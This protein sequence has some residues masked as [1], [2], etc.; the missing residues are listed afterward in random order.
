MNK[1][2][3][4]YIG[5]ALFARVRTLR[6]CADHPVEAGREDVEACVDCV[7]FAER[8]AALTASSPRL[9]PQ[10]PPIMLPS[11]QRTPPVV[12]RVRAPTPR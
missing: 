12:D 1:I 5:T 4:R 10:K 11:M 3:R 8:S 9:R 2:T 7:L 6:P